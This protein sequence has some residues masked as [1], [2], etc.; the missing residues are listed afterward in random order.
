MKRV[1]LFKQMR[2]AARLNRDLVLPL[3]ERTNRTWPLCLT[4]FREVDSCEIR[5]LSPTG[6][7]IVAKCC[8]IK[9]NKLSVEN[10]KMFED[11]YRVEFPYRMDE[12]QLSN[13]DADWAIKRAMHD[14]SPFD[15]SYSFD[16]RRK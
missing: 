13:K 15:P 7:E 16:D 2:G 1:G 10:P 12:D 9:D 14:F 8:H 5:D 6:C 11:Y 4:C 3:G